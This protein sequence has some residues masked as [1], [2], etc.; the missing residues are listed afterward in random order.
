M[1]VFCISGCAWGDRRPFLTYTPLLPSQPKNNIALKILTFDDKRTIKDTVGYSRNGAGMRCAKVIPQNSVTEWVTNAL[2]AELTNVGYSISDQE[3]TLN[4]IGGEVFDVFCDAALTYDGS[5]GIKVVLKRDDKV[6][7]EK[8]YSA[9]K[10]S[11]NF[12]ATEKGF[13]K[14]LEITLQKTLKQVVN[15]INKELSKQ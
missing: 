14:M 4:V 12:V 5:I 3:T 15:D 13:A 11:V 9:K 2:K 10:S 1:I 7:L 8:D 6:V